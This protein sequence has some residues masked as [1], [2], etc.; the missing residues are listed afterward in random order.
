MSRPQDFL[1][2]KASE[3]FTGL[4]S[5]RIRVLVVPASSLAVSTQVPLW[6]I[7]L[8]WW[9]NSLRSSGDLQESLTM[10]EAGR[11]GE[12]TLLF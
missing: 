5:T 10:P 4:V 8:S 6:A 2:V 11:E 9:E 3:S 7:L 12:G 1:R